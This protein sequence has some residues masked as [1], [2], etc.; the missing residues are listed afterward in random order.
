[1]AGK[2]LLLEEVAGR[3]GM[4]ADDVH[5]LV[6]RKKLYPLRDGTTLK[7]KADDIDRFAAELA[8]GPADSGLDLDLDLDADAAPAATGT[9]NVELLDDGASSAA[10]TSGAGAAAA[11][12]AAAGR[13]VTGSRNAAESSGLEIDMDD[14]SGVSVFS[15]SP[16][17]NDA[18]AMTMLGT[19]EAVAGNFEL[20]LDSVVGLSRAG[21][22]AISGPASAGPATGAGKPGTFDLDLS[23]ELAVGSGPNQAGSNPTG[24]LVGSG[25]NAID[26]SNGPRSGPGSALSGIVDSGLSLED[27]DAAVSGIDLGSLDDGL[28]A[29]DGGTQLAGEDFN[30]D[31]DAEGFGSDEESASVV[32]VEESGDSSFFGTGADDSS[33]FSTDLS[34]AS[35]DVSATDMTGLDVVRDS[36]FSLAQVIG[37]VCCALLLL[38]GGF[39]MFDLMRTIGSPGDL[40]LSSP[41]L[42]PLAGVFGWR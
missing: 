7:F 16:A 31:N 15:E 21:G 14:N 42:N 29:E 5:K 6:D 34:A 41:L 13:T 4:S 9:V 37:L 8:D 17:S 30:V 25:G 39:V 36:K 3:L 22:S 2:F 23:E 27:G 38:T 28:S 20:D 35:E 33:Q 40:T 1:M 11:V 24:S 12:D 18:I 32:A 19:G 26:L 10:G